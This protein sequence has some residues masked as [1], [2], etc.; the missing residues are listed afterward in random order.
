M[1]WMF[2]NCVTPVNALMNRMRYRALGAR[3]PRGT[4]QP[5]LRRPRRFGFLGSARW[6]GRVSDAVALC[7]LALHLLLVGCCADSP[8][9]DASSFKADDPMTTRYIPLG[10]T[11]G[12]AP[13]VL[14]RVKVESLMSVSEY[15]ARLGVSEEPEIDPRDVDGRIGCVLCIEITV[16]AATKEEALENM[17]RSRCTAVI[18]FVH[19]PNGLPTPIRSYSRREMDRRLRPDAR[20]NYTFPKLRTEPTDGTTATAFLY[21]HIGFECSVEALCR[22]DMVVVPRTDLALAGQVDD[23]TSPASITGAPY[24]TWRFE[25]LSP[26]LRWV[27]LAAVEE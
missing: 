20:V 4:A 19:A 3:Q 15:C 23:T 17:Q 25:S 12:E 6:G 18:G 14:C 10:L 21:F 8:V 1:A 2:P 27:K 16:T 13:Q 11:G 7:A 22:V 24:E 9:N 26:L 5:H